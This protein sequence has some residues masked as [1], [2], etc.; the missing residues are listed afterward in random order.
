ML[1]IVGAWRLM[2]AY[3][4]GQETGDRLD[5][6]GPEPFGSVIFA[7]N[8]RMIVL[9]TSGGRTPAWSS[10]E[11]AALFKSMAAYTGRWAIDGEKLVTKV[12]G[13]WDPSW[14]GTDQARYYTFDG[15]TL[16]VRT[17]PLDHP[18]FPGQKVIGY[19]DWQREA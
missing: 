7:P 19:L 11:M 6:F 1:D 9:I 4:V 14:V 17:A 12:D 18:S 10:A 8:G 15:L 16:S 13:A 2:S 3:F 5:L